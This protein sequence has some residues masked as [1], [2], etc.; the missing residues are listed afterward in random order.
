MFAKTNIYAVICGEFRVSA[1]T[2]H[3]ISGQDLWIFNCA[4]CWPVVFR[5][6]TFW[7]S[8]KIAIHSSIIAHVGFELCKA[9][10]LTLTF[11]PSNGNASYTY[12]TPQGRHGQDKTVLSCPC[13]RCEI[14]SE[15]VK[16]V[17]DRKFQNWTCLAFCRLFA[18]FCFF[19]QSRNAVWI[20]FCLALTHCQICN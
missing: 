15:Q 3:W 13:L 5:E 19:V 14:N 17:G 8:V 18:A 6:S 1:Y 10:Q 16:T 20:V 2:T 12:F 11:R 7:R 4:S 9:S